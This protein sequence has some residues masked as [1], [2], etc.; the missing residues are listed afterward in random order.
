MNGVHDMGGMHGL[1]PVAPEE[2]EPVFHEA[3]E[4][5]VF[6]M[7]LA[8]GAW[9][10]WNI[11][12]NRHSREVMPAGDYLNTSY[13]EHW[14]FGIERL[15]VEKGL[16][17]Q[18][19]ID[20]GAAEG[21]GLTPKLTAGAVAGVLRKGDMFRVDEDVPPKFRAGDRVLS[22]NFQP[23]GHTRLPR[24]ARGRRGEIDR[25]HGVFIFPDT[26]ARG[27]GKKPQ[28]LY[29]VRFSAREIWGPDAPAQDHIHL[30]LWDDYLEPA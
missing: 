16:L 3:W 30:D 6:A 9:G 8:M 24:Y 29:S 7:V 4:K 15:L 17:T 11:D 27:E 12:M 1:G 28:H 19:E 20:A 2:N 22:R 13:Y 25:D 14:L 10:K 23:L 5:R 18:E 21:G 26:N